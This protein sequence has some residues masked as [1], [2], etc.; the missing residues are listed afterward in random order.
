MSA[1]EV[2]IAPP[3]RDDE[4]QLLYKEFYR[5]FLERDRP[6][7]VPIEFGCRIS[8]LL[9]VLVALLWNKNRR[10]GDPA[11]WGK[12]KRI[13]IDSFIALATS[14][15]NLEDLTMPD[16][17]LARIFLN[18]KLAGDCAVFI[19]EEEI[20]TYVDSG[21]TYSKI[22]FGD[23]DNLFLAYPVALFGIGFKDPPNN[24][25]I[26]HYFAVRKEESNYFLISSYGSKLVDISQY[27]TPLIVGELLEY[28]RQLTIPD[29]N[30]EFI[31]EFMKKYFLDLTHAIDKADADGEITK[32][33]STFNYEVVSFLK[34]VDLIQKG[35]TKKGGRKRL[36]R[37][38]RRIR[39]YKGKRRKSD[40]SRRIVWTLKN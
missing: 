28:I 8:S 20:T 16:P 26:I 34:A 15:I 17:V 40:F 11:L 13:D 7:R 19:Q 35:L 37:A 25:L 33:Y 9:Y 18:N 3:I 38:H 31:R 29:R 21:V 27:E 12:K 32:Y 6:K 14:V 1:S 39:T 5:I 4:Y 23:F 10:A 36:T 30:M 2:F 22:F 24:G